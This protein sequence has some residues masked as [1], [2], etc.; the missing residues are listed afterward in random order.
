MIL[1]FTGT[2]RGMT[3]A[4]RAAL[5]SV[6]A[7]LPER[8]LH[9]GAE[10]ADEEF[11]DW[12]A[13]HIQNGFKWMECSIYPSSDVRWRYWLDHGVNEQFRSFDVHMPEAPL[14]RNRIIAKRCDHLLACPVE[15]D[16][17]LRS[18]TWATIRAA[19]KL[20]KLIT[21]ILPDGTAREGRR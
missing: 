13:E 6:L 3:P 4:Q 10:G 12:I 19:R 8:V 9:G 7:A 2:R 1:G 11:H 16:E 5:P 14:T 17:Q 15:A 18:G 20:G 21:L